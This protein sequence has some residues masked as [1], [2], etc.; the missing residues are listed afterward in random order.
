[1]PHYL[2]KVMT[3][4]SKPG[5]DVP[6]PE[7]ADKA[8][9]AVVAML[10]G[11]CY[12]LSADKREVL[13]TTLLEVLSSC[14]NEELKVDL[15]LTSNPGSSLYPYQA[16]AQA[17]KWG[18]RMLQAYGSNNNVPL[19]DYTHNI[20][21]YTNRRGDDVNPLPDPAY[22]TLVHPG[23]GSMRMSLDVLSATYYVGGSHYVVAKD[24]DLVRV[25]YASYSA[26]ELMETMAGLMGLIKKCQ[27][28]MAF[29]IN[30][31]NEP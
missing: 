12:D 19:P 8:T 6:Y 30:K 24:G 16:A 9:D 25:S 18:Y 28:S 1:M 5:Q 7:L 23:R 26:K 20:M 31:V 27:D 3:D 21:A 13:R 22:L 15:T 2:E 4:E 14:S 17:Y 10:E 11:D 29:L